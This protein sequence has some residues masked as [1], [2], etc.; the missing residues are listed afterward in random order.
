MPWPRPARSCCAWTWRRERD[1]PGGRAVD[2]DLA[3]GDAG[4]DLRAESLRQRSVGRGP[5]HRPL[6]AGDSSNTSMPLPPPATTYCSLMLE[7]E[8]GVGKTEI[9][10]VLARVLDRELIRLQC[11]EGLDAYQALYE[12]DHPASCWP[13]A[14]ARPRAAGHR[15]LRARVPDRTTAPAR[16]ARRRALLLIDEIDRADSE[17]EAFLLEFLSTS[18]SRSPGRDGHRAVPAARGDHVEPDARAARRPQT[19]VP[20]PLDRLS[21]TPRAKRDRRRE[22]CPGWLRCPASGRRGQPPALAAGDDPPGVAETIDWAQA[23]DC[24]VRRIRGRYAL[25]RTLGLVVKEAEDAAKV[26]APHAGRRVGDLTL[27]NLRRTSST[28]LPAPPR[29]SGGSTFF[30][31]VRENESPNITPPLLAGMRDPGLPPR[32]HHPLQCGSSSRS[33]QALR[34]VADRDERVEHRPNRERRTRSRCCRRGHGQS[35][36]VDDLRNRRTYDATRDD[37]AELRKAIAEHVRACESRGCARAGAATSTCAAR[38]ATRPAPARSRTSPAAAARIARAAAAPDR[39]VR[40]AAREHPRLPALRL[41]RAGR[42]VHVRHP[43]HPRS[44]R[45][46]AIVTSMSRSRT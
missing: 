4:P 42:D 16:A 32:G 2:G 12:W 28:S 9:A 27:R 45:S 38:S 6:L 29:I 24:S 43:A 44:P 33:S 11:Y 41:G 39:R 36:S 35:A 10:R 26:L 40:L 15:A 23:A 37:L 20:L 5:A 25:D 1:P 14:P 46:C 17:F 34:P 8:P 21:R 3:G 31:A 7:G 30:T 22:G 19:P 13:S 18:R